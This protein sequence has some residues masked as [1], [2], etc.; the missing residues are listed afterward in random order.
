MQFA[1]IRLFDASTAPMKRAPSVRIL[2]PIPE[3]HNEVVLETEAGL[4]DENSIQYDK[5]DQLLTGH[6]ESIEAENGTGEIMTVISVQ[7]HVPLPSMWMEIDIDER[8]GL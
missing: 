4:E 6:F 8:E 2:A 3:P 1:E 5:L 7:N